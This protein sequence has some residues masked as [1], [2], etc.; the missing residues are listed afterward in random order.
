M[1]LGSEGEHDTLEVAGA[2]V[3]GLP[4]TGHERLIGQEPPE[5]W[6]RRPRGLPGVGHIAHQIPIEPF[7]RG[8][9]HPVGDEPAPVVAHQQR[10][11]YAERIHQGQHVGGDIL[12]GPS[13]RSRPRPPVP[14]QIGGDDPQSLRRV[15][16][17]IPVNP[18]MLRPAM[19]G[20]HRPA[21]LRAGFSDVK[22]NPPRVNEGSA[23]TRDGGGF[24]HRRVAQLARQT[25]TQT[26]AG[27][28]RT[29]A[30]GGVWV[31]GTG[32]YGHH[33]GGMMLLPSTPVSRAMI[34]AGMFTIW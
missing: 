30:D 22:P 11:L 8:Q 26:G 25:S 1:R 31:P 24:A 33:S 18:V 28:R 6:Q 13:V 14:G 19:Q 2:S 34:C 29:S 5:V 15:G 12:L 17:Q 3:Q 27:A 32:L 7:G 9:Q 21:V 23:H 10:P 4:D 16:Q 20:D